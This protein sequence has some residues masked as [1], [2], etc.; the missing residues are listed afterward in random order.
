MIIFT[1]V[2]AFAPALGALIIEFA[3]WRSIFLAFVVF[4]LLSVLWL[5]VRLPETLAVEDRRPLQWP[6]MIDAVRQMF[7]QP[8]VRISIFVQTL[9]MAILFSVLVLIQPTYQFVFDR[10]ESFPYWFGAIALSSAL[11]SF[12]NALLVMRFGMRR[13]ITVAMVGQILLS[14]VVLLFFN[15]IP[16][17]GFALFAVWQGFV[18]FQVGLSIGN[19]NAIAMEPMGHIAGMAASVIGAFSTVIAA[20]IAT[21]AALMFD[22]TIRPIVGTALVLACVA[23]ALMVQMGRIEARQPAE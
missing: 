21:P 6:L 11:A 8:V 2:P 10:L 3:G 9:T 1:L 14:S 15:S 23:F 16:A 7:D 13:L 5:A 19:L 20:L 18:F 12:L 17:G 4:S 22:G